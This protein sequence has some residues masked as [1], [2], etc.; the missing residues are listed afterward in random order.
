MGFFGNVR[1]NYHSLCH[2]RRL[3]GFRWLQ[4]VIDCDVWINSPLQRGG[5]YVKIFRDLSLILPHDGKESV[6]RNL[7]D[8]LLRE[9][10][11]DVI[12]RYWCHRRPLFVACKVP[13]CANSIYV[14]GGYGECTVGCQDDQG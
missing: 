13:W 2:L 5:M 12:F 7:F 10:K 9:Q 4:G 11:P 8:K 3:V 1:K 14:R 6:T